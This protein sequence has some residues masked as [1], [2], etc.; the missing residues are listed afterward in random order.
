MNR[1]Y[2]LKVRTKAAYGQS[3]R[4]ETTL[5]G[6]VPGIANGK[7]KTSES[8]RNVVR[9]TTYR[10]PILRLQI[11]NVESFHSRGDTNFIFKWTQLII[12]RQKR[13]SLNA[14]TLKESA[15]VIGATNTI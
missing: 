7:W 12:N 2:T 4:V 10:L 3:L 5:T 8:S 1:L 13:P 9:Y 14:I 6:A 11:A 15:H